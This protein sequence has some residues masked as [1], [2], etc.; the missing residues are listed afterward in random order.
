[1]KNLIL[2]FLLLV[3]VGSHDVL[4]QTKKKAATRPASA[5]S[6]S[7]PQMTHDYEMMISTT[8]NQIRVARPEVRPEAL[9]CDKTII[10]DAL[11]SFT[12]RFA[13]RGFS[14]SESAEA[15]VDGWTIVRLTSELPV[16]RC[17]HKDSFGKLVFELGKLLLTTTPDAANF[18]VIDTGVSGKTDRSRWFEPRTYHVK[19]QKDGYE[20]SELDCVVTK[21]KATPCHAD[22]KK[23]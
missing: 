13:K 3:A 7:S 4:G 21:G 10:V 20:S 12:Q 5:M 17:M 6:A 15:A 2:M 11:P 16:N 8:A 23:H 22:L 1:M 14:A 9:A 18:E 19:Y